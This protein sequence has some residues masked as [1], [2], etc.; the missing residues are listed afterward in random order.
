MILPR[1]DDFDDYLLTVELGVEANLNATMSLRIVVQDKYD[2]TPAPGQENNDI[3]LVS[4]LT[5]QLR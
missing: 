2:S 3:S 1:T 5:W 4:A